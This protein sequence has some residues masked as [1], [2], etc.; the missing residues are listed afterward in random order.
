MNYSVEIQCLDRINHSF[1]L[2]PNFYRILL[3]FLLKIAIFA[4][5][6]NIWHKIWRTFVAVREIWR[7]QSEA[8]LSTIRFAQITFFFNAGQT[9]QH[10]I[11][12]KLPWTQWHQRIKFVK[13]FFFSFTTR[14]IVQLDLCEGKRLTG[15]WSQVNVGG[16]VLVSTLHVGLNWFSL[17]PPGHWHCWQSV[18][19]P[20][21]IISQEI[22][23][24][25]LTF[26]EFFKS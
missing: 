11:K 2:Y 12:T 6:R 8:A 24:E 3:Y 7:N 26:G 1:T 4:G 21:N 5:S 22:H 13:L 20:T 9:C 17:L 14:R 10:V 18:D 19:V 23:L 15:H 16:E 25:I